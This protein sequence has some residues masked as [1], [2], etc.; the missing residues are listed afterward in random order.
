MAALVNQVSSTV[1]E[2]T[3]RALCVHIVENGAQ[4]C[5]CISADSKELDAVEKWWRRRDSNPRPVTGTRQALH[6]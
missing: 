4:A 3:E 5:S 2:H 1:L 6:A